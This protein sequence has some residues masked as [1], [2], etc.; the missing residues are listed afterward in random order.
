MSRTIGAFFLRRTSVFLI[1]GVVWGLVGMFYGLEAWRATAEQTW[2]QLDAMT[3]LV[4]ALS[5]QH[6]DQYLR[7]FAFLDAHVAEHELQ[8]GAHPVP[9]RM[10]RLLEE[11]LRAYPDTRAGALVSGDGTILAGAGDYG[12]RNRV[13]SRMAAFIRQ[14]SADPAQADRPGSV[15]VALGRRSMELGALQATRG[16][17]PLFVVVDVAMRGQ[18]T[19]WSQLHLPNRAERHAVMGLLSGRGHL[20]AASPQSWPEQFGARPMAV[21]A[22]RASL[23]DVARRPPSDMNQVLDIGRM[24]DAMWVAMQSLQGLPLVAFVA[25]P[26]AAV[27]LLWW[28]HAR[29]AL[30]G[31]LLLG[32]VLAAASGSYAHARKRELRQTSRTAQAERMARQSALFYAALVEALRVLRNPQRHGRGEVL[33]TLAASLAD[34]LDARAAFI[35]LSRRGAKWLEV[36]AT[37]GPASAYG[38]GLRISA[39]PDL[40]E[41]RGPAGQALR[42]GEAQHCAIGDPRFAPWAA[43]ARMHGAQGVLAAAARTVD[44]GSALLCI[45][46]GSANPL[47]AHA[48]G[49]VQQI[50]DELAEFIEREADIARAMRCERYRGALRSIQHRLLSA[51]SEQA[52]LSIV[53]EALVTETDVVDVEVQVASEDGTLHRQFL[54]RPQQAHAA[55]P[56]GHAEFPERFARLCAVAWSTRTPQVL[57]RPAEADDA[58]DCWRQPRLATAGALMAWPVLSVGGEPDYGVMGFVTQDPAPIDEAMRDL[59]QRIVHSSATSLAQIR[60]RAHIEW[61]AWRDSLTGLYNRRALLERLPAMLTAARRNGHLLA[62]CVLDLDDFKPVNDQWGHAAGDAL[63]CALG[64]RLRTGLREGDCVA[65]LG[66][67]EFVLVIAGLSCLAEAQAMLARL[68][69]TL[70]LPYVLPAGQR[71]QVGLSMGLTVFPDDDSDPQQLLEHADAALY[72]A[73]S[74]KSPGATRCVTWAPDVEVGS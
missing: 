73:K 6:L 68:Q 58:D 46:Y 57:L 16:G 63:L 69:S 62:V 15:R 8:D 34:L 55:P 33:Q 48:T 5:Q 51:G 64:E 37:A 50:A 71:V 72:R 1:A 12:R 26:K 23:P 43:R 38:Q 4:S 2:L 13:G 61:L 29:D 65:R 70:R 49:V 45:L 74:D 18:V 21:G 20:I 59:L 19:L 39:D 11:F 24:H 30:F 54:A 60:K 31:W 41:G 9:R 36:V 27:D 28:R 42:S 53:A 47:L 40:P 14:L 17:P 35:A 67:D 22:M 52:A 10:D 44:G 7:G 66:G 25:I 32:A 3:G 56:G